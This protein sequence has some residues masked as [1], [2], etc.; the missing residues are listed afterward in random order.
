V[1]VRRVWLA[2]V[3][4]CAAALVGRCSSRPDP[5]QLDSGQLVVSN[6]EREDWRGVQV[7]LNDQYRVTVP[8]V[9]A[10]QQLI[11]PL[12]TFV[13]GWGQRFD[14]TRQAVAGVQVSGVTPSRR[15][16]Y[17]TWGKVR[18]RMP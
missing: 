6:Q 18:R 12:D 3:L 11:V 9:K 4:V 7:W 15:P 13:A 16:I 5:I 8:E 10:G 14:R 17:L 2:A 1:T